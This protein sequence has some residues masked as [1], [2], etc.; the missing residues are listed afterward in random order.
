MGYGC[1]GRDLAAC[2]VIAAHLWVRRDASGKF[3]LI[4]IRDCLVAKCGT[5]RYTLFHCL[6]VG[7][8]LWVLDLYVTGLVALVSPT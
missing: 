3:R 8:E 5:D 6:E 2:S 1:S 4:V 7:F